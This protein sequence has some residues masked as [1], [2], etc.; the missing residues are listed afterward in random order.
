MILGIVLG[1][2]V[3][4]KSD[5]VYVKLSGV[6]DGLDFIKL[7]GDPSFILELRRLKK[8]IHDAS[9]VD[10][11]NISPEQMREITLLSSIESNFTESLVGVIIPK[12]EEGVERV[13]QLKQGVKN[14]QWKIMTAR[15]Y[16]EAVDLL[17][18]Y[19]IAE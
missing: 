9:E 10:A 16:Q 6:I 14:K 12:D 7:T 19:P 1:Y 11:V 13:E 3:I 18:R 5:H 8:V 15:N 17:S 4:Q 2:S